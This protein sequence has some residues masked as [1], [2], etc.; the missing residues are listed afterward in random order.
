MKEERR[1][2]LIAIVGPTASGKSDLGIALAARLHGEI[3]NCDSVQVFQG[4]EIATA[5]VPLAER[6]GIP[7]HLLDLVPPTYEMTAVEWA[8][9]ARE[10]IQQTLA[11]FGGAVQKD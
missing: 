4:I 8:A 5:K 9:R 7:H 2:P 1:Q 6:Q 10:A 3:I 11:G